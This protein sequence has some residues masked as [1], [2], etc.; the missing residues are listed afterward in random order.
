MNKKIK[1]R[2]LLAREESELLKR[3]W[4]ALFSTLDERGLPFDTVAF[5]AACD[6]ARGLIANSPLCVT[7][8][9]NTREAAR[10]VEMEVGR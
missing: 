3:A 1:P 10:H 4:K 2:V 5:R 8:H 6:T 9:S 7:T